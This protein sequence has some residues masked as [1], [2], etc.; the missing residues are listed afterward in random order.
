M[1]LYKVK[2]QSTIMVW[3]DKPDDYRAID[4]AIENA[5]E[6][7]SNRIDDDNSP[8][9][10]SAIEVKSLG[11]IPD[12]WQDSIPWGDYS[13]NKTCQDILDGDH[14]IGTK[15]Q[16]INCDCCGDDGI[17]YRCSLCGSDYCEQCGV[18]GCDCED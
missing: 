18:D 16:V 9:G 6:E 8:K 10:C 3:T 2:L 1:P 15:I 14:G 13:S 12:E 7:L 5:S 17:K 11:E 4:I